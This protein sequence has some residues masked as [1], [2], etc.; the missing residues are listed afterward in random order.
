MGTG[1]WLR[2]RKALC[3]W[4]R[5]ALEAYENS[6]LLRE[7]Q[8]TGIPGGTGQSHWLETR[9]KPRLAFHCYGSYCWKLAKQL[10]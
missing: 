3:L 2:R 7:L 1:V 6:E 5:K 9:C 4:R 8:A 10:G